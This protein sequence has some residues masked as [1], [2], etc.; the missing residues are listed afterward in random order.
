MTSKQNFSEIFRKNDD[1]SE[2]TWNQILM[3]NF[4]KNPNLLRVNQNLANSEIQKHEK[5]FQ[6][7]LVLVFFGKI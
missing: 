3:Q 2:K 5:L 6:Y 7:G 4:L 1:F